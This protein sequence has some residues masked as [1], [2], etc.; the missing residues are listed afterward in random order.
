MKHS[1]GSTRAHK[2]YS[3]IYKFRMASKR[4]LFVHSLLEW[5][6]TNYAHYPWRK[7]SEPYKVL[8]AELMLQRTKAEQ[9]V[10][11]YNKFIKKFPN[12][13]TLASAET[14]EILHVIKPLGLV[15]RVDRFKSIAIDILSKYAGVVPDDCFALLELNGVGNYVANA[16]RCF[17][18]NRNVAVVDANIARIVKRIFS[19]NFGPD[20]HKR[21]D[22]WKFMQSIIPSD[23]AREF[24]WALIDFGNAICKA[25][26]PKCKS[27]PLN[28]ICDY[29]GQIETSN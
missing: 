28:T 11:V 17:A 13:K 2:K 9:V 20:P 24:N 14:E 6:N 10:P 22:L 23:R 29:Y 3:R 26:N 1:T 25:R 15:Y 5:S 19:L 8:V 16:L 18:Y 7:T 27:C 21:Q 12:L 4:S